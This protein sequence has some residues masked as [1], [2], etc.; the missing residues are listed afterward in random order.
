MTVAVGSERGDCPTDTA[1]LWV[2]SLYLTMVTLNTLFF[3][4]GVIS[5]DKRIQYVAKRVCKRNT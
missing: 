4:N 3:R 2:G 5:W 1:T